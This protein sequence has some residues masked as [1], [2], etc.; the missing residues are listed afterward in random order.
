MMP[1][2]LKLLIPILLLAA[3]IR[4]AHLSAIWNTPVLSVPIIDSEFYHNWASALASGTPSSAEIFFMSPAYPYVLSILYRIFGSSTHVAAL[5]QILCGVLIV[6]LLY[7][8]GKNLFGENV[9]LLAALLA[10][11]Y[12]PFIYYEGVL[13][14]ATFILL[15]N[16]C[17]LLLLLSVKPKPFKDVLAGFLLGLSALA[18]PNILLFVFL[19]LLAFLLL[20]SLGRR[21]RA[22][23]LVLGAAIALLPVAYRNYR[24]GGEF[25][26]TTA[27]LGMNFYAGNNPEADGIYWEAPFLHSAEPQYENQDYRSAASQRTGKD[28]S[29]TEASRY[30]L[31]RG[32]EFITEHPARYFQ[33]ITKKFFLFFHRTEIP[34]N[35]SIYAVQDFSPILRL[36]PLS[37]GL[38]APIGI[39]FWL[40]HCRRPGSGIIH[41][42]G[43]S[44]LLATLLFFAASEYRLPLLLI[45][46]PM[47][48]AG[49]TGFVNHLKLRKQKAAFRLILFI[50]L[51][52]LTINMPTPFTASLVSP[53]MDYFNWGSVL[54]K[55]DRHAE[56]VGMLKRALDYDPDFIEAHI[57]LGDSYLALGQGDLAIE[58]FRRAG[59]NPPL[60]PQLKSV[61]QPQSIPPAP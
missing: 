61:P 20:P 46:L 36:V 13:L 3:A 29:V 33:L 10:A 26:L 6:F 28:L 7:R 37:F 41:V 52:A 42:Y 11:L 2:K 47:A 18:R 35:L 60:Q 54:Q 32:L 19:L 58:E 53:R 24:V 31:L 14:S 4:I 21:S 43:L 17:A 55:Q 39:A 9:G 45:L 5:F 15:L 8:L 12:R 51:L 49:V 23:L 16:A 27:A 59:L 25:V 44:Y 22:L 48:A 30:W 50:I 34:N 57:A 1:M 38:I 40:L 56:A